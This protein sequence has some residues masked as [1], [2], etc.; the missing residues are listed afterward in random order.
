MTAAATGDV[1]GLMA[2][3]APDVVWTAD[4][5]GKAS[6]ARRPSSGAEKVARLRHRPDPA[7]PAPTCRVE[8]AIYNSAPALVALPRRPPGGRL[9]RSRSSTAR[10]PTSTRSATRRSWPHVRRSA[11][12]PVPRAAQI[13]A[14]EAFASARHAVRLAAM[15][16]ERLGDLGSAAEVLRAVAGAAAAA[17]LPP[18]AALIGDWFGSARG[19]RADGD[20][21][22]PSTPATCSTSPPGAGGAGGRR[23]MDRLP[24]VPG[25]RRRRTPSRIPEAAGGWTDCVLRQD[26]DGMLVVREPLRRTDSDI[27]WSTHCA[28]GAATAICDINWD[29]PDRDA[30]RAGVLAL[31][32]GDRRR[33]G[34]IRPA[35][36]RSSPAAARRLAASTSSSTPSTRTAPARAAFVAGDWGAVASLSPELFLRRRGDDGDV[37]PDQGHAAAACRPGRAAGLGQGRRREHHDRRPGPQRPGPRR[38]RPASVTRAG[39]A[40]GAARAGRVASGVDGVARRVP[41]RRADARR[42]WTRRSRRRRSPVRRKTRARAA[43]FAVGAASSRG[44]LRHSRF[45]LADRGHRAERGDPD[46]RVRR[47]TAAP[48]SVSAAASRPTPIR[49]ANGR[50]AC[51]RRH[52]SSGSASRQPLRLPPSADLTRARAAP[53]RRAH[54]ATARRDGRDH[55]RARILD[56]QPVVD[57]RVHL[58]HQRRRCRRRAARPPAR[59]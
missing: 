27:G 3:L 33:R 38:G 9:H 32:G 26:R 56:P 5:D 20:R 41:R 21:S 22:S 55:L 36:A 30:H 53:R 35:C 25:R 19:H 43:A 10:S 40:R 46:R 42:C 45:G 6:A 58:G 59:R 37:E 31:P 49:T 34:A 11:A 18:P 12:S 23:R 15:R 4:S 28:P 7:R 57:Q 44:L 8:P 24:V 16:I 54:A 29:E 39:T 2:M 47:R 17:G 48:C 13:A 50:S 1:D 52:R 14:A 51:T